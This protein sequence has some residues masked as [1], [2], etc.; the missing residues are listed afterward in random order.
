MQLILPA[1]CCAV[2]RNWA[3]HTDWVRRTDVEECARSIPAGVFLHNSATWK[4]VGN[5]SMSLIGKEVGRKLRIGRYRFS[6]LS[7]VVLRDF[8]DA[9]ETPMSPSGGNPSHVPHSY[10]SRPPYRY[11]AKQF[12]IAAFRPL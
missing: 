3:T 9:L 8:P 4:W 11:D 6:L 12:T 1:T 7:D 10:I 2:A 5:S